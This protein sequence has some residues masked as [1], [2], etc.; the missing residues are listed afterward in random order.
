MN[1]SNLRFSLLGLLLTTTLI[2]AVLGTWSTRPLVAVIAMVLASPLVFV[3][4]MAL[5]AN[6]SSA[7]AQTAKFLLVVLAASIFVFLFW[8]IVS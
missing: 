3:A 7:W 5:L 8:L 4:A 6:R 1:A 2:A